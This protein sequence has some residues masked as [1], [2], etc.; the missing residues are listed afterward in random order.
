MALPALVRV[1]AEKKVSRFCERRVPKQARH[2]VRLLYLFRGSTVTIVE[3]RAPWHA[4]MKEWPSMP[5]AQIRY[6]E[7]TGRW[8]LYYADAAMGWQECSDIE[9][10]RDIDVL[11]REIDEDST[12]IFWG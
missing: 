11:L 5:I 2:H 10:T 3:R 12:G 1:I 6:N 9:A 8:R 7:K 4:G